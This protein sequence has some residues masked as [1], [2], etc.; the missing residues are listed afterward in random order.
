MDRSNVCEDCEFYLSNKDSEGMIMNTGIC[1]RFPPTM[2]G[3]YKPRE[4]RVH[5]KSDQPK[6][7]EN[8]P[9]CGEFN[10]FEE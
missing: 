2:F 9:C 10:L 1:R 7:N 5:S 3:V 4:S 6:V 8:R